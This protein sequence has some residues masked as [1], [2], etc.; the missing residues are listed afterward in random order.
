MFGK[1]RMEINKVTVSSANELKAA[2]K[3]KEQNIE[4]TGELA[5]KLKW[6]VKLSPKKITAIIGV[7][8][9]VGATVPLTGGASA[10]AVAPAMTAVTGTEL[11]TLILACSISVGVL[12][13]LL[14]DYDVE[15]GQGE[16]TVRFTK[17]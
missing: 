6:M 12:V 5:K 17:K 8:A 14:K 3:K 2:V 10:L 15:I 4:V 16:M 13:A 11:A 1:K 9:T 7:L